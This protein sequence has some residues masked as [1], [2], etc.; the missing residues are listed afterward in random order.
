MK[1]KLSFDTED[2]NLDDNQAKRLIEE[3]LLDSPSHLRS[4][5]ASTLSQQHASLHSWYRPSNSLATH[6]DKRRHTPRKKKKN[7]N[8]RNKDCVVSSCSSLANIIE[9]L[10][11]Y[12]SLRSS[13]TLVPP[14]SYKALI[15]DYHHILYHHLSITT[16]SI[17]SIQDEYERIYNQ[18]TKYIKHCDGTT[19]PAFIRNQRDRSFDDEKETNILHDPQITFFM[20]TLDSI[21]C[22]LLHSYHQGMRTKLKYRKRMNA[23]PQKTTVYH[24]PDTEI[25]CITA[26]IAAHN[27]HDATHWRNHIRSKFCTRLPT[28]LKKKRVFRSEPKSKAMHMSDHFGFRYYYHAYFRDN[29]LSDDGPNTGYKMKDMYIARK[30]CDLKDEMINNAIFC[31][32]INVM[33][34]VMTKAH[35]YSHTKHCKSLYS[36]DSVYAEYFKIKSNRH[37]KLHH[38]IS[39]ILFCDHYELSINLRSTFIKINEDETHAQIKNRHREFYHFARSLNETVQIFGRKVCSNKTQ[40][41]FHGV[42][43]IT[44]PTFRVTFCGPTSCTPMVEVAVQSAIQHQFS[45]GVLLELIPQNEYSSVMAFDCSWLSCYGNECEQ[46]FFGGTRSLKFKN[47]RTLKT[48]KNYGIYVKAIALFDDVIQGKELT[49]A[50]QSKIGEGDSHIIQCLMR[51]MDAYDKYTNPHIPKYVHKLFQTFCASQKSISLSLNRLNHEYKGF[52]ECLL[53]NRCNN[54]VS[55]D[56]L[57]RIF[58]HLKEI[59]IYNCKNLSDLY[60]LS[61]ISMLEHMEGIGT[62]V[63]VRLYDVQYDYRYLDHRFL[64]KFVMKFQ[65]QSAAKISIDIKDRLIF[66]EAHQMYKKYVERTDLIIIRN[67]ML[68]KQENYKYFMASSMSDDSV[69]ASLDSG[70]TVQPIA[71][72][73]RLTTV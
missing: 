24:T 42:N 43:Q 8:R 23:K 26:I 38:V 40:V 22:Y 51:H 37:I 39:I 66:D 46:L 25:K 71:Q 56:Y 41:Y 50:A 55:M 67:S 49:M 14:F 5:T 2:R 7:R 35:K 33:H 70:D 10:V 15:N 69:N 20:D 13:S 52:K 36:K 29:A 4:Q 18:M 3:L 48:C 12:Q 47:I 63:T 31:L 58:V 64:S 44:F 19:C 60:V 16:K 32:N 27:K 6:M 17:R 11:W 1:L 62:L 68:H 45:K 73:N 72:M 28:K 53:S 21:H 54:L 61:L 9:V 34:Q 57:I 30:Y 65:L 59:N